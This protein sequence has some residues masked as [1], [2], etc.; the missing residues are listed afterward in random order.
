MVKKVANKKADTEFAIIDTGGKQ[1]RVKVGETVTIEKLAGL[2]KGDTV[3]FDKV[4]LVEDADGTTIGDPYI[5]GAAVKAEF[6]EYGRT[7]KVRVVKYKAKARYLKQNTHR[8][9]FCKVLIS[10]IK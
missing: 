5:K 2:N 6:V 10:S 4:L 8:Q 7:A 3:I 1:Y 9:P